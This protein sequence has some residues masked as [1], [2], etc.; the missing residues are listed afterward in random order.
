MSMVEKETKVVNENKMTVN[1]TKEALYDF[2]LFH[3]YSKFSGF[4][5]NILGLAVAFMGIFSY[6]TGRVSS[7][8]AVLYL[9]AAAIF[10]GGTPFQLKMRAKKQVV[11]NREYNA[12]VEYT[13]SEKGITLEQNGESKTYEW[14]QIER[15]VVTPKTIGIYYAPECAMILPKED[16]GDQFVPIFTTIATQLGQSKVRMR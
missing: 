6:T 14:E 12:P 5:I 11:V 3:A 9:V 7:I 2:L 13:F 10:L 16:F 4:L 15:A 1:M 8:G